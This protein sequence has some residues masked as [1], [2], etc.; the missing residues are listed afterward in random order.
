VCV[1]ARACVCVY[2]INYTN[3]M[4]AFLHSQQTFFYSACWTES[5]MKLNN[6]GISNV[7]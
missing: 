6:C 7:N 4:I 5:R 3:H 1:C 2:S